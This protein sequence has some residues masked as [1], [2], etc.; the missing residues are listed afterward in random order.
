MT[1]IHFIKRGLASALLSLAATVSAFALDL[2]VTTVNGTDY[3]YYDVQPKETLFSLA[4]RLGITR[5][6]IIR[7]NPGADGALKP[8]TRLYFPVESGLSTISE[9]SHISTT[10][11]VAKGETLYGISKKYGISI[12]RLIELNPSARDGV[13]SGD[14]LTILPE[15]NNA[16]QEESIRSNGG[17]HTIAQGETL[18]RIAVNNGI[19]VEQLL[20]AN[21]G[22]DAYNYSEGTTLNIPADGGNAAYSPE[23]ITEVDVN[24]HPVT[25]N[26]NAAAENLTSADIDDLRANAVEISADNLD[27]LAREDDD[28]AA[29]SE[30]DDAKEDLTSDNFSVMSAAADSD[31]TSPFNLAIMLPFNLDEETPGKDAENF[32]EFYRGVLLAAQNLSNS[33]RP[34]NIHAYDTRGSLD[35][36][37]EIMAREEIADMDMFVT[38]ASAAELD[39]IISQSDS[40]RQFVFN[41]FAV[42]SDSYKNNPNVLQANIPHTA[43]YQRAID[44]FMQEM[45]G[46]TPIFIQRIGAT[47]DKEEFTSM[48]K[49]Q[50]SDKGIAFKEITYDHSLNSEDFEGLDTSGSYVI[51][52]LSSSASEFNKIA[53]EAKRF[54]STLNSEN[55]LALFGYPEWLTFRGE[56]KDNLGALNATI[57]SRF[58]YDDTYYPARRVV[59][60]YKK[61]YG[62]EMNSAV[63]SQ[64]LMGYDVASFIIKSMR[65]NNGDFHIGIAPYEGL[66]SDFI[67]SDRDCDGLV[68]TSVELIKFRD[69]GFT[70]HRNI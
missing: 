11:E 41:T 52:P 54:K 26:R 35:S 47:A 33:G 6:E 63:P 43:M 1:L 17:T 34:V 5:E 19:T 28:T 29:A 38:P 8:Y 3:Y 16:T 27:N 67:F 2:P 65:K 30:G 42:R 55:G 32:T 12:D 48:L 66:Q 60:A 70:E 23:Q 7:Y 64:A 39:Y 57:Y 4:Q 69:G 15:E 61:S 22:L 50:L 56:R 45:A 31:E 68:N 59:E 46:R 9:G 13:K 21:P 18:Y 62:R 37:K 14:R 44:A 20:A 53:P 49:S 25:N 40:D 58:Y 51:V 10:H 24:L 36:V